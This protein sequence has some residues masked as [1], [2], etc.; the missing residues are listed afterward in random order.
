MRQLRPTAVHFPFV[1]SRH[2]F[3]RLLY[4]RIVRAFL[5]EE[6]KIVKQVMA[7]KKSSKAIKE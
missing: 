5:I 4:D 3:Q 2:R 7:A 1:L 6:R